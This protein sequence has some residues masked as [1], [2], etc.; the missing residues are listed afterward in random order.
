MD[1]WHL[2]G[3]RE[4]VMGMPTTCPQHVHKEEVHPARDKRNSSML[5]SCLST[6]EKGAKDSDWGQLKSDASWDT[7][8]GH[9]S[10]RFTLITLSRTIYNRVNRQILLETIG[11]SQC[12]S[13][14]SFGLKIQMHSFLFANDWDT[15]RTQ[16][17]ITCLIHLGKFYFYAKLKN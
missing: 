12:Q 7:K 1:G 4:R 14:T 10:W 13:V 5:A 6:G 2:L 11:L 9:F 17:Y 3:E 16:R 8:R 15:F